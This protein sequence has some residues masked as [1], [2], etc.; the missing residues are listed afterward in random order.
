MTRIE[1]LLNSDRTVFYDGAMGTMLQSRGLSPGERSDIMNIRSPDAVF[2]IHR[3]YVEAGSDIIMTNTLGANARALRDSGHSPGRVISAAVDAARRAA[4]NRAAVALDVGPIGDFMSPHGDLTPSSAYALFREQ[5][6][7]GAEAG[8]ELIAIETMSDTDELAAAVKAARD[9]CPL[10]VFATMTFDKSGR[11]YTGV[12]PEDFVR[13]AEEL[14]VT[15]LGI[16]CSLGPGESLPVFRR[17][18]ELSRLPLIAKLNAGLPLSDGSYALSPETFAAQM[19]DYRPLGV[20]IAGACCG[21]SPAFIRALRE[22][23]AE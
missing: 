7:I 21:S 14:G 23:F 11:T 8:A 16:N 3:A 4:G 2:E 15:A 12:G 9:A 1:T 13:R 20:K 5:I 6:E 18:S 22:A 19:L 17:L 10:P